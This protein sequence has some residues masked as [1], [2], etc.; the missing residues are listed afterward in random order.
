MSWTRLIAILGTALALASGTAHAAAPTIGSP[1]PVLNI[2]DRGELTMNGEKFSFIPWSSE[3]NP[4]KVHIIQ[5]FGATMGDSKVFEPVTD[6]LETSVKPGTVHV[7][8]VLNLDAALW[9]T[10]GFVM[11]ELEKNKK[12]HPQATMVV[13]E[14]GAG[15]SQWDLGEAGTGLIVMDDQ[16]IVKYFNRK[17]LTEE[18]L[19]STMELIRSLSGN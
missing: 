17:S 16:G 14:D 7:S 5:Y 2:T 8:T 19:A 11:S 13:D 1:L 10:T 15:V 6:L 9:G 18:E 12:I 3:T 4:G